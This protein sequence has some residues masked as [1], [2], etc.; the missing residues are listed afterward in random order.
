MFQ[1]AR[2]TTDHG[3]TIQVMFNPAEYNLDAGVNY[4]SINVPGLDGPITQYISGTQDT[5]TIQ[6][7]FNTYQPPKYDPNAKRIV[8]TPESKMEDVTDYTAKI[9]DLTRIA[10][11]LHRPPV[12][13]FQW[14]SLHFRG[15][16]T[17]VKQKFTMF[18]EGGK[19]V[20]A[21]VDMT[22]QSVL[23]PVFSKKSSPWESPDRTKYRVLDE[24]TSLWQLAYEE[25]GDSEKWKD[26]CRANG[27]RNPL[28]VYAGMEIKLPPL[29][30]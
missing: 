21:L 30:P 15:V 5:L 3:K 25:Y 10:G 22:F 2:I 18:L 4:S 1:K 20:R 13:T 28:D 8:E 9:Y 27:I 26:I 23:D 14:G 6:L 24:S 7:M 12:C 19:P 17:S 29:K 16:V 11:A